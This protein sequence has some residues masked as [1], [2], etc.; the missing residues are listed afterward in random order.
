MK[1]TYNNRYNSPL[2]VS[3]CKHRYR[4]F[5][6]AKIAEQAIYTGRATSPS[7]SMAIEIFPH[8]APEHRR[9]A[10]DNIRGKSGG[11]GIVSVESSQ[12]NNYLQ[13]DPVPVPFGKACLNLA[14]SL[15][16]GEGA[17]VTV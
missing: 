15:D 16:E 14:E 17:V 2:S 4:G 9:S 7:K 5:L 12:L 6:Y 11:L 3:L 10:A 1:K 8:H 13:I